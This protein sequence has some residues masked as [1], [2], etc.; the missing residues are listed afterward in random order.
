[1]WGPSGTSLWRWRTAWV[2]YFRLSLGSGPYVCAVSAT[3][4]ETEGPLLALEASGLYHVYREPEFETVALRGAALTLERGRWIAVSGPSGS[5]KSTLLHVLC[6]LLEP[7]GGK[8]MVDGRDVTRLDEAGRSEFRRTSLGV[9]MQRDNLHPALS[10]LENVALPLRLNG[11]SHREARRR[12]A[13]ALE[14]V[15]LAGRAKHRP[16]QLSGGEAQRVAIA[17]AL[18]P[19]PKI[20]VADEPTGEL[21]TVTTKAVL[22]ILDA[23]RSSGTAVLTVT[24]NHLVAD[25]ADRC[26]IM[27]DGEIHNGQ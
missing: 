17:V 13:E 8:V 19:D 18:V 15:G 20:L 1:M 9:V 14:R 25:Q 6:G 26:L 3:G 4:V 2:G 11:V 5:G 10:A 16:K 23:V 21:D 27:R 12:A 22:D 7:T 24:H